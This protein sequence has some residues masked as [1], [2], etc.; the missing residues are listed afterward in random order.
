MTGFTI[1]S[2]F[3][4]LTFLSFFLF[5][6]LIPVN[7]IIIYDDRNCL[8]PMRLPLDQNLILG[9]NP[10]YIFVDRSLSM[11]GQQQIVFV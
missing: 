2:L 5:L 7:S 9:Y 11:H 6:L 8:I 3:L 10:N 4:S 1:I